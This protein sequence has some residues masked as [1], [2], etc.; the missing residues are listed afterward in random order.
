MPAAPT[1]GRPRTFDVDQVLD[2][3]LDEFWS[4]G[5]RGVTTRDLE[6][7]LGVSQS[8]LYQAFGSK[9]ELLLK[10]I[11]RYQ[12][13][14]E[15]DLFVHLAGSGDGYDALDAFVVALAGW[16]EANRHRGCLVVNLMPGDAVDETIFR[17]VSE[18]RSRIRSGLAMALDRCGDAGASSTT[19]RAD[20][21]L[22]AVLGI[23]VAV[24][25]DSGHAEVDALLDGLRELIDDWRRQSVSAH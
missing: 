1:R 6:R 12:Q 24:R 16:I 17:R 4:R 8:S 2:S 13:R 10:V 21:L 9:R 25:T 18:Y 5:Y 11:D 23:Q 14:V 3:A 19:W 15:E 20:V 7:L 22:A